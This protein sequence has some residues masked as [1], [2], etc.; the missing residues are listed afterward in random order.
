M[1]SEGLA[2]RARIRLSPPMNHG[3]S[4]EFSFSGTKSAI[5]R[6]V[7]SAEAPTNERERSDLCAAFQAAVTR[8]LVEKTM[9][10][11]LRLGATRVVV[12]GGVAA[13]RG[14]R[15]QMASACAR[16]GLELHL[17]LVQHC[18]DNAAMIAYA[19]ALRL[20]AGEHDG[21]ELGPSTASSL[22]KRTR[23]GRGRR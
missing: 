7:A 9:R 14:L 16:R 12:A 8:T 10:A 2:S 1:A 3:S 23:K 11:A 5:A 19:G 20:L 13:N 18:T 22:T 6:H 17:P 15:T 4:L 21:L